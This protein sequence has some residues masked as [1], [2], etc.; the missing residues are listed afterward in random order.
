MHTL[1]DFLV[2]L[3]AEEPAAPS[4]AWR[5]GVVTTALRANDGGA[6]TVASARDRAMLVWAHAHPEWVQQQVEAGHVC[7]DDHAPAVGVL[8]PKGIITVG[9]E[10]RVGARGLTPHTPMPRR[11][12]PVAAPYVQHDLVP[13]QAFRVRCRV[14]MGVR[15]PHMYADAAVALRVCLPDLSNGAGR[16]NGSAEGVPVAMPADGRAADVELVTPPLSVALPLVQGQVGR[17]D[18]MLT[19]TDPATGVKHMRTRYGFR[20][21]NLHD[22]LHAPVVLGAGTWSDLQAPASRAAYTFEAL[23]LHVEAVGTD[24]RSLAWEATPEHARYAADYALGLVTADH[25]VAA[26]MVEIAVREADQS[27]NGTRYTHPAMADVI[28][29]AFNT[30]ELSD[31]PLPSVAWPLQRAREPSNP[32]AVSMQFVAALRA[33]GITPEEAVAWW[34]NQRHEGEALL[35]T[36]LRL[37][38]C[39]STLASAW[40]R[41]LPYQSDTMLGADGQPVGKEDLGNCRSGP[42][43]DDCDGSGSCNARTAVDIAA[44][45]PG[46]DP[47]LRV[48][49]SVLSLY[50]RAVGIMDT[51]DGS[52]NVAGDGRDSAEASAKTVRFGGHVTCLGFSRALLRGQLAEDDAWARAVGLHTDAARAPE[53]AAP[54]TARLP[55]VIVDEG[56]GALNPFHVDAPLVYSRATMVQE[57]LLNDPVRV[58]GLVGALVDVALPSGPDRAYVQTVHPT[59]VLPSGSTLE[60]T[61]V[62]QALDGYAAP[63]EHAAFDFMAAVN[64][65]CP[66]L[67][68]GALADLPERVTLKYSART[69]EGTTGV[70]MKDA[71]RGRIALKPLTQVHRGEA[72]AMAAVMAATHYIN[73]LTIAAPSN[74]CAPLSAEVAVPNMRA[75]LS[76]PPKRGAHY[77]PVL[78]P[79]RMLTA[80]RMRALDAGV[81]AVQ[82]HLDAVWNLSAEAARGHGLRWLRDAGVRALSVETTP[83][84]MAAGVEGVFVSLVFERRHE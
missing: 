18:C 35:G 42:L 65:V 13:A 28:S 50:P 77:V 78:F 44:M 33:H 4:E 40:V 7:V 20:M 62:Q 59:N 76:T 27:V 38:E 57:P 67:P 32:F 5:G 6:L 53:L 71:L 52:A 75:P 83:I 81:A 61:A 82:T 74:A 60:R 56:T 64:A 63:R 49:T 68:E 23:S 45:P 12:V 16:V 11:V 30:T 69:A 3:G 34:D 14:R 80:Q 66:V 41:I 31:L 51:N 58:H 19:Y 29:F 39:A 24:V 8:Y 15:M 17:V 70:W 47:L 55:A 1:C 25:P 22:A 9:G 73:P 2:H 36:T 10:V 26:R 48:L 21:F 72:Q 79:R 84:T 46:A 54:W 37:L 43:N